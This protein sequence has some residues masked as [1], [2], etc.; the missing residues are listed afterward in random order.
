MRKC[1]RG[2]APRSLVIDG[3]GVPTPDLPE[4]RALGFCKGSR[5][6]CVHL[7]GGG[8]GGSFGSGAAGGQNSLICNLWLQPSAAWLVVWS[9]ISE[10]TLSIWSN[11]TGP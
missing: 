3:E 1:W 4:Q 10:K 11:R 7:R 2:I 5:V 9:V 6:P 8:G